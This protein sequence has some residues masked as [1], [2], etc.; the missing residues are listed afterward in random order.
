MAVT[1]MAF[2]SIADGMKTRLDWDRY[3]QLSEKILENQE[4][5]DFISE[6]EFQPLQVNKSL[7]KFNEY[8][9]EK[10]KFV[11]G[12]TTKIPGYE[13]ILFNNEGF[14][15]VTYRATADTVAKAE[16]VSKKRRVR[17]IGMPKDMI[18]ISWND[19]KSFMMAAM[20]NELAEKGISTTLIHYPSFISDNSGFDDL[21]AQ[22]NEVKKTEVLVLDDIGAESNNDW[23]RDN[24][25]QIIL[26][27]RMQ[28]NLPTFFT[29]NLTMLEL[30]Q[31]LAMTKKG[32]E[33]W[34][35]KRVMERV[36]KLSTEYALAGEN[37]RNR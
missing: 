5:Q 19:G 37:R 7:S 9:T 34:S 1:E 12:E 10:A 8:V 22:A 23:I 31:R 6:N 20:A 2:D 33:T 21:K 32:D 16:E 25:L 13:P 26:Q 28:E 35:A 3:H 29:S 15:D 24:I 36:R 18:D 14:A 4:I 17:L 27:Y 30:E 11:S